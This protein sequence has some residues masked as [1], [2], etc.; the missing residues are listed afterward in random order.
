[1]L[2]T[3]AGCASTLFSETS[4]AAEY[5]TIM[6]P[7]QTPPCGVRKAGSAEYAGFTSLSM[8]RSE[9]FASSASAIFKKSKGSAMG[10]PWKLPPEM[11]ALSSLKMSGLSVTELISMSTLPCTYFTA[12]LEAP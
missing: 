11:P 3:L 6:K 5:C 1:M 4:A 8:R 10:W 9:T 7:E 12:S 2:S